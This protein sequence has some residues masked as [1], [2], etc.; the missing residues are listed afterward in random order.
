MSRV[1]KSQKIFK[2]LRGKGVHVSKVWYRKDKGF[3]GLIEGRHIFLGYS[4]YSIKQ[5]LYQGILIPDPL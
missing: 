4:L 2:Y 1:T 5:K 3:Y